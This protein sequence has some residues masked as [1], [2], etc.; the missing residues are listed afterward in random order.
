MYERFGLFSEDQA[1]IALAPVQMVSP[2]GLYRSF[3]KR[4]VDVS[5]VA[6][7][8]IPAFLIIAVS[9]L[10]LIIR[11]GGSPFYRQERVG[12]NGEKFGMWKMRTM[13]RDADLV[14][15]EYLRSNPEAH[16]EWTTYQK[17]KDDPRITRFG[18]FLRRTSLDEL[19]QVWNVLKGEMSIVGP[20]PMMLEQR[21]LYPGTEYYAMRPG[22]T[23]LW[24]ISSRNDSSF[25]ER[26][27]FDQAYFRQ[28]SFVTD[29]S[30]IYRTFAVVLRGTGH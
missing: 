17:L 1:P 10:L 16:A 15:A 28:L 13:V 12:L 29:L 23:G 24:Q 8:A 18:R 26:A 7:T 4:L 25:H 3:A 19:P 6:V 20:R 14:L 11:E 2:Q 9:A 27:S 5:I 30:V 22:I 21:T